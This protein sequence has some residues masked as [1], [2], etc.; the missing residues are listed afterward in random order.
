M[1]ARGIGSGENE[2]FRQESGHPAR[3][4]VHHRHDLPAHH[5][6][7]LVVHGVLP[8]RPLDPK[9]GAE[10]DLHAVRRFDRAFERGRRN[11]RAHAHVE[12]EELVKG[13]HGDES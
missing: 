10:V 11:H 9:L 13:G 8:G 7:G 1:G 3:G 12:V 5:V 6:R 2:D 4:E